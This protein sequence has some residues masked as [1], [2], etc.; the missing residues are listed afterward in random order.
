MKYLVLCPR[1]DELSGL[2]PDVTQSYVVESYAA[3]AGVDDQRR[4]ARQ[5][6]EVGI[7]VRYIRTMFLPG[8]E[9]LLHVF[10]AASPEALLEAARGAALSYDRIIEAVEGSAESHE[11]EVPK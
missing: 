4:R 3:G 5:A 1:H 9:T 6:A 7:G 8:D 11:P 10:E 2:R